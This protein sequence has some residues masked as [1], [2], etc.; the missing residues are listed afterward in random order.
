MLYL[1]DVPGVVGLGVERRGVLDAGAG[2]FFH[3]VDTDVPRISVVVRK[4]FGGSFVM[5]QARQAGGDRVMAWPGA[6]IGIA[7]PEV[8]FAILH[9]KQA[10]T[11]ADAGAFKAGMV[12]ELGRTPTDAQSA[13][14]A[15][16]I[17]AVIQ[18]ADTRE[19][20]VAALQAFPPLLERDR[21]PRRRAVL[22]V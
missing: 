10:L 19:A 9:G 12:E 18:P 8:A 22:Q 3:A 14:A 17:D 6:Q 20:I 16:L 5:L 21:P 4:C 7:G 15:G 2:S 1:V 11:H 13:C